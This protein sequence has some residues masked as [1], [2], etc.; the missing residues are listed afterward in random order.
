ME[1]LRRRGVS[2]NE[3]NP[4]ANLAE[5]LFCRAFT[6][7]KAPNSQK[8]FSA[9]DRDGTRYQIKG[10]RLPQPK[11][12]RQLSAIRD[13]EGFDMLA[14]VLLDRE[15]LVLRAAL[16]PRQ[17]VRERCNFDRHTNSYKFMLIDDV[18]DDKRVTDAIGELRAVSSRN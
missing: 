3:N 15:Y 1:Q 5:Y 14:A 9:T 6:W 18:W 10:C 4:T 13:L 17:V 8:G 11:K 7:Q 16:I 2:R 12:S